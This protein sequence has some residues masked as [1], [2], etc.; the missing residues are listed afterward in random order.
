MSRERY[1]SNLSRLQQSLN[2]CASVNQVVVSDETAATAKKISAGLFLAHSTSDT[3]FSAICGSGRLASKARLAREKG[4]TV[5]PECTECRLGT[6]DSVFFYAA[7][8]GFRGTNCGLLFAPGMEAE[9]KDD[10]VATPFDSGGLLKE[11]VIRFDATEPAL[12]FLSRHE[13]SIP[14]H[15]SY[16]R[17]SMEMLFR[18]P[19][20]YLAGQ[21]PQLLGPIGLS[22]GD[23]RRWTHEVR[24][25]SQVFLHNRHLKAVFVPTARVADPEIDDLLQ[26][27]IRE[28]GVDLVFFDLPRGDAFDA[29]QRESLDYIRRKLQ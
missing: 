10:G 9:R 12:D 18:V 13:L 26:W 7:P 16:L 4:E 20:D 21:D 5:S 29:L 22:G 8:F 19:D 6:V 25:P 27:C 1:V 15:R 3:T 2:D 23:R 11:S 14:E 24:L 28:G 17:R